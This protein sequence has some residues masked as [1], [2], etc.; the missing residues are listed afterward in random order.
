MIVVSGAIIGMPTSYGREDG[1]SDE[2]RDGR[3]PTDNVLTT[4]Y[5]RGRTLPELL[6][7]GA[8]TLRSGRFGDLCGEVRRAGLRQIPSGSG[9]F[10]GSGAGSAKRSAH[11]ARGQGSV[12]Y[13]GDQWGGRGGVVSGSQR[14]AILGRF[15]AIIRGH[16]G[17]L[18]RAAAAAGIEA[19]LQS[20]GGARTLQSGSLVLVFSDD[21]PAG[22]PTGRLIFARF[23]NG[24]GGFARFLNG[25]G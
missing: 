17:Q 2:F 4:E 22:I 6:R 9:A 13:R 19:V 12:F 24:D 25:D 3:R 1:H 23:S 16:V 18:G 11:A 20:V 7:A 5:R 15:S 14:R 21:S 8:V 10:G